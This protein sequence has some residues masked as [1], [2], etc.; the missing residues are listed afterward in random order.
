MF[1]SGGLMLLKSFGGKYH[2]YPPFRAWKS[3][4]IFFFLLNVFLV[5]V[6][7]VP[8]AKDFKPYENL[9]YWVSP[10]QANNGIQQ[11]IIQVA[12]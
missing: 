3:I 8:P 10:R 7:L 5:F 6:P 1:F 2:W 12:S 11:A 4:T 9:P